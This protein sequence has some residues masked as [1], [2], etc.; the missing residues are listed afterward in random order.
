MIN[1]FWIR[2]TIL[3]TAFISLS[4]SITVS[5]AFTSPG[6]VV[7]QNN[8]PPKSRP[9]GSRLRNNAPPKSRDGGSRSWEQ[10]LNDVL[11]NNEPPESRDGGSRGSFCTLAPMDIDTGIKLWNDQPVFVWNGAIVRL[12]LRDRD[13]ETLIWSQ[14][15][16]KQAQTARYT[17]EALQAGYTYTLWLYTTSS[18]IP[19]EQVIFQ[20]LN[21]QQQTAIRNE[22]KQLET[23]LDDPTDEA[24]A[25]ARF[26]Y[27]A[28]KQLWSDAISEPFLVEN[29]SESLSQFRKETLP[30]QFCE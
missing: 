28:E 26:Q 27:F 20:L 29:P 30:K 17:G 24:V 5:E 10:T 9:G 4:L 8:A 12:E 22:I 6:S 19:D 1:L 14:T 2:L 7:A 23:S 13:G 15:V 3:F 25:L 11:L 18:F 21:S 16:S